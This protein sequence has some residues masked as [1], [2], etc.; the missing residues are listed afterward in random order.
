MET[1]ANDGDIAKQVMSQP[2]KALLGSN[3]KVDSDNRLDVK[4]GG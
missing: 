1:L 4:K 3:L 2:K